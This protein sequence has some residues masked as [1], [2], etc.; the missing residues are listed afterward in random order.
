M[1]TNENENSFYDAKN[2]EHT[3]I[4]SLIPREGFI[5]NIRRAP[6]SQQIKI[7]KAA[8]RI[9][10]TAGLKLGQVL[11][12]AA[13]NALLTYLGKSTTVDIANIP[14]KNV[15]ETLRKLK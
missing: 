15:E 5:D 8:G 6:P 14:L 9:K 10:S 3:P 7:T 11:T 2:L 12:L 13:R 4:P 1:A